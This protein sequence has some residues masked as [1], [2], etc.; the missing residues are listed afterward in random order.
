MKNSKPRKRNQEPKG[1]KARQRPKAKK[2]NERKL[3]RAKRQGEKA[4]KEE[5][6]KQQPNSPTHY[7]LGSCAPVRAASHDRLSVLGATG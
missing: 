2:P 3:Q 1:K 6:Q 7:E 5:P 4:V